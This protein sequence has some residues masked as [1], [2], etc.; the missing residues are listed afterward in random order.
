MN[1]NIVWTIGVFLLLGAIGFWIGFLISRATA[2]RFLAARE[3]DAAAIIAQAHRQAEEIRQRA[4]VEAKESWERE[5]VRFE[6]Q[7]QATRRELERMESKIT[8]RDAFLARRESILTQKEVDLI[9]KERELSAREKLTRAKMERLDQLIE[10]QN[11]RLER[12]A[13]MSSEE[14]RRELLRN[15]ENE[16]RLEAAR[17]MREIKEEAKARAEAEAREV[18]AAA[19]Q[20]CA[21]S[22]V[23]E[24]TVSV[25]NL[26]SDELKGRIIGREGRNI[27][28]FESI[29]GV[30]V[31]IDDTPGAIIISGFDPV[32]REIA[33]R[34]M[35]RLVSDGR[36][37]PA[38]IEEVV[39]RTQ[40][41]MEEVIRNTGEEAI[42]E[43]G[44]VGLHPELVQLLGRLRYRTS[45]GQNV[46]VHS[47]EVAYL[48]SLMAQELDLDP[49]IAKRA[50][51]LHDIGKAADQTME[52]TH[53]R[54][55]AELARRYGEEPVVV[56]AIAAHHEETTLDSPYAFLVAAADSVSGSRPGARRESF[57]TY[58]KRIE[59]LEAIAASFPGVEK[60]Y[61]VQA[62]REI[63]VLVEPDKVNDQDAAELAAR[64]AAQIETEMKYPG[65]IKVMVIRETR[66]VDY[67]H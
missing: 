61:A 40:Q 25:V 11:A 19:I 51:L 9:R 62:G 36:I 59:G 56:N 16:A 53:A 14:A 5:R 45:Y 17:M 13:G 39:A 1:L 3:S 21:I 31:M 49:A 10:Q 66:A 67:A 15:L 54:I 35:E 41:E 6:A 52:G 12:I 65:Q 18:I 64:I 42:L 43:L 20:R 37:H 60:A 58:I 8:E 22:H 29:T 2:R 57:E 48:A 7:T 46:L 27:R 33:R 34:A 30:E 4:E 50:G 28:T 55:G 23:A 38:R 32:R 44:I 24:T 47:R 26:P 63:R